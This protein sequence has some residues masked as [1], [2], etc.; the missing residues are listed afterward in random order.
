MSSLRLLLACVASLSIATGCSGTVVT[1]DDGE[2]GDNGGWRS[3]PAHPV[4][5]LRR[6]RQPGGERVRL[7]HGDVRAALRSRLAAV[8][9]EHDLR[10]LRDRLVPRLP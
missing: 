3:A 7:Q 5:R 6:L 10:R 1:G 9:A 2:G 4:R 8:P